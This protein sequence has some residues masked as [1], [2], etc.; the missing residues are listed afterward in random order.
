M[1]RLDLFPARA[2]VVCCSVFVGCQPGAVQPD[3][4]ARVLDPRPVPP[5][6]RF[7][8]HHARLGSTTSNTA[9]AGGWWDGGDVARVGCRA[10]AVH[11]R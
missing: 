9:M 5:Q 2:C 6:Q 7:S 11:V 4:A 8:S 3:V 1:P 10:P